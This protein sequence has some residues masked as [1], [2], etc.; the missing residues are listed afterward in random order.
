MNWSSQGLILGLREGNLTA[1][2]KVSQ[3]PAG[4]QAAE[5][6]FPQSLCELLRASFA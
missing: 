1:G 2:P 3:G 6:V 5:G 4:S